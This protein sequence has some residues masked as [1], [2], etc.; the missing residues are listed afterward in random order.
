MSQTYL[1]L[2]QCAAVLGVSRVRAW[3]LRD[4]LKAERHG[5][6]WF[7][8]PMNLRLYIAEQEKKQA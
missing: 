3:Q 5:R 7:V 6:F 2:T 8:T 1:T 4:R